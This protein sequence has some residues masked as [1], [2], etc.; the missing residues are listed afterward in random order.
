MAEVQL[1]P[2]AHF[3]KYIT[4]AFA[5]RES[6]L[7]IFFDLEKAYDTTWRYH[8]LQKLSSLGIRGN[9]CLYIVFPLE[10]HFPGQNCLFDI[11]SSVRRHST[12]QCARHH[13]IPSYR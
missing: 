10:M 11:I 1:T 13:F 3:E 5:G 7:S 8:S 6:V 2:H 4:S 9:V 12:R